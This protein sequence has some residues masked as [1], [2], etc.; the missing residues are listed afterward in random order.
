MYTLSLTIVFCLLLLMK[1]YILL[2][3]LDIDLPHPDRPPLVACEC[4]YPA[5]V[6]QHPSQGS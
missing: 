4:P 3:A 2:N 1:K 5:G 6:C